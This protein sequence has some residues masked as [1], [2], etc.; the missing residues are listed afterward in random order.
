MEQ[1]L[2]SYLRPTAIID[3]DN[4][5]VLNCALEV[6]GEDADPVK[7]AVRLYYFV[8][9]VI[10]YDPYY[11][12]YKP[13]HYRASNTLET[14]NG[15]CVSKAVLLCALARARG[16]PS[17][18]GFADVKNHLATRQLLEHLGTDIFVYHGFT[19]L[20]LEGK[21][22]KATPAFNV[23]LCRR[24][25]VSPLDFDGRNDSLF[26]PYN[27]EKRK[28]MEYIRY[29]GTFDDVP[30]E[31]ILKAWR[32]TYGHKRVDRWIKFMEKSGGRSLR[33]FYRE[34]RVR[35]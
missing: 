17:R 34:E 20:Y 10:W 29:H 27:E 12:F 35:D 33:D 4:P 18:L 24:H 8:R 9:D 1:E 6:G 26:H 31:R 7:V 2:H 22:V 11:P 16:I 19:E 13:E 21:W 15:Y 23:E 3:S 5:D 28:F 30:L 32:E 25:E 14:K